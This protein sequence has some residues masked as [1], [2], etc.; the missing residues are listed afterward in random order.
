M[1][2][3]LSATI[4]AVGIAVAGVGCSD[5]ADS[6]APSTEARSESASATEA[7][8]SVTSEFRVEGMT[9]GGCAVATEM[10]VEK[11]DGVESADAEYLGEDR[12]GR[13]TVKFDPSEVDADRIA[14]AI[15]EAGYDPSLTDT[16]PGS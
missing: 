10:A 9:C 16:S 14:S 7:T 12:P 13:C 4:A 1:T 11:L 2:K 15:E 6:P 5:G 8:R 3:L